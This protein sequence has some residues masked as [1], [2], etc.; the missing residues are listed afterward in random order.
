MVQMLAQGQ[1]LA[2]A[3]LFGVAASRFAVAAPVGR[4]DPGLGELTLLS[5]VAASVPLPYRRQSIE[6]ALAE[7]FPLYQWQ[8]DGGEDFPGRKLVVGAMPGRKLSVMIDGGARRCRANWP[9]HRTAA[10]CAS[11]SMP[12][13]IWRWLAASH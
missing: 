13:V 9:H 2:L 6:H 1:D 8:A 11:R 5:L 7:N 10:M 12:G 4:Y 3:G